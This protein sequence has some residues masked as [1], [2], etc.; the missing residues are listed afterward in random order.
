VTVLSRRP[1]L[2]GRSIALIAILAMALNIRTAVAAIS[3]IV[4]L[5]TRDV[6]LDNVGL[7]LLGTLPPICFAISGLVAP[8]VA[9]RAGLETT[10]VVAS[11]AIVVGSLVR[12]TAGSYGVLVA[13]GIIALAGMGFG[14]ILLPPA[15]KKYFPDRIGQVTAAYAT[16]LAVS[17]SLPAVL[18][19]PV[20]FAAG[21]RV[22]LGVWAVFAL[23]AL[24]PW[25]MLRAQRA[26]ALR[27]AADGSHE[28]TTE[29][30][31]M[32]P[33]PELLGKLWRSPVAWS[34]AILLAT[35]A[36]SVY[37]AYTW[38]PE[39]LVSTAGQSQLEAG[40]VLSFYGII[41]LPLALVVPVLAARL[42][43]VGWL[44]YPGLACFV[45]GDLGFILAPGAAPVLWVVFLGVGPLL[46]PLCLALIGLR[47][48][49][50][51][52]AVAVSGFVQAIGYTLGALGPFIV[53]VIHNATREWTAPLTFLLA[54]ALF[55]V[56]AAV[57]LAK[58]K[59]VEDDL[60]AV[61]NSSVK[62]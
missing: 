43:N 15:V 33:A 52:T 28:A 14:N 58:P 1:L 35:S 54:T 49:S 62:N 41:S 32:P 7:G 2:A 6:P 61:S 48:R 31:V 26:G 24:L 45:I 40:S 21:W 5:I 50:P 3:P 42:T 39:I 59:F 16:V 44:I 19:A 38:L 37:A 22:S 13:G 20:A 29:S 11:A 25:I 27:R 47:T 46:F 10:L 9:R 12:A 51:E 17:V 8:F 34:I 30:A 36:L 60:W 56:V 4:P 23:G 53:G 57:I 55:G 18:A